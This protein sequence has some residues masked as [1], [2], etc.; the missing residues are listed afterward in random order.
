[1]MSPPVSPDMRMLTIGELLR[2]Q[3]FVQGFEVE[4]YFRSSRGLVLDVRRQAGVLLAKAF[5][6]SVLVGLVLGLVA[7][8]V[9]P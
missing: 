8:R 6:C 3:G 4:A 5:G 1:M 7:G 9:L 2:A